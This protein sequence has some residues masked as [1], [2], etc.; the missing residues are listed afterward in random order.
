VGHDVVQLAG[1]PQ[2]FLVHG[3]SRTRDA[4]A[5]PRADRV[6][7][8]PRDDH[9]EDGHEDRV[10]QD[11]RTG[12]PPPQSAMR[13]QYPRPATSISTARPLVAWRATENIAMKSAMT[14]QAPRLSG[15][16]AVAA[17]PHTTTAAAAVGRVRRQ[18]MPTVITAAVA[19]RTKR[20]AHHGEPDLGLAHDTERRPCRHVAPRRTL[21]HHATVVAPP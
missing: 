15:T 19:A 14:G 12:T 18:T 16:P 1:D 6:A 3:R 4:E 2:A 9:H 5:L 21:R 20:H 8:D 10:E 13:A 17:S 11:R 7:G